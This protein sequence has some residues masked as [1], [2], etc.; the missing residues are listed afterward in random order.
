MRKAAERVPH[1][2]VRT[3][4]KRPQLPFFL[5]TQREI[6]NALPRLAFSPAKLA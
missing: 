3:V 2:R 6:T 4:K 5:M 1:L